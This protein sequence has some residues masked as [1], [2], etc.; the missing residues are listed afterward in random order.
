MN[1]KCGIRA[2][3]FEKITNDGRFMVY[4]CEAPE[5]K[6]KVKCDFKLENKTGDISHSELISKTSDKNENL[7]KKVNYMKELDK[8][9]NLCKITQHLPSVYSDNY[10]SNINYILNKFNMPIF[11]YENETIDSLQKR[12]KLNIIK[13][14]AVPDKKYPISLLE[15]EESLCVPKRKSKNKSKSKKNKVKIENELSYKII[16]EL[17]DEEKENLDT[18]PKEEENSESEDSDSDINED[19]TFDVDSVNSDF[20]DNFND[21]DGAFSD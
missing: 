1:C 17:I 2:F 16:D 21:D 15:I 13:T 4:R 14:A 5:T 18:E 9:I 20:E 12:I 11:L 3:S 19:D 8:Y 10:R 7:G 6:K